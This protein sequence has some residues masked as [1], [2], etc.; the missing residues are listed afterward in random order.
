MSIILSDDQLR[1]YRAVLLE[2][3]FG[4]IG[5]CYAVH[6]ID[7]LKCDILAAL[8]LD[9]VL[10]SVNDLDLTCLGYESNV[11]CVERCSPAGAKYPTFKVFGPKNHEGSGVF[12]D[13]KPQILVTWTLWEC[14]AVS[15]A[16]H[17]AVVTGRTAT[18]GTRAAAGLA[19]DAPW[20]HPFRSPV[21]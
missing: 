17:A 3:T 4:I 20:Q 12:W 16:W 14:Q 2:S 11:A 18:S 10:F 7:H 19:A 6:G 5:D 13:Q 15:R 9:K 8:E 1:T 21:G